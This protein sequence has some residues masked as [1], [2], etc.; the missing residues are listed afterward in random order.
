MLFSIALLTTAFPGQAAAATN[1]GVSFEN[2][3][4]LAG[5]QLTLHGIGLLRWK[6]VVKVYL[7]GLYKPA[8]VPVDQV[9]QDVP[10]RLEYYFFVDMKAS[11]FQDTGF[12]LMAQ[13]VGEEKARSLMKELEIFNSFYRDVKAGQ[14]YAF[15]Y[16]PGQGLE[17]ELDGDVLGKVEDAEFAAAYMSIWLGPEPV[18][19]GL[20]EGLFDPSTRMD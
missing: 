8:G 16:V 20:Q 12:Q 3:I 2:E 10:K 6:Y 15:S 11:D 5:N 18:S 13:N 4:T 19:M 17:M 9:L 14:R 1:R 7:V